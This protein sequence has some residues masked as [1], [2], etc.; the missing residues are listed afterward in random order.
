[1]GLIKHINIIYDAFNEKSADW[2]NLGD[3]FMD[4]NFGIWGECIPKIGAK[5]D[6]QFQRKPFTLIQHY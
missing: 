6:V 5:V 4:V 1:M 2:K 3:T